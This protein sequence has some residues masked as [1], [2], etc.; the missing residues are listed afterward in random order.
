[1]LFYP[2]FP[3]AAGALFFAQV[4]QR[5]TLM[6]FK[7]ITA[8]SSAANGRKRL[9]NK[10]DKLSIIVIVVLART[11]AR[12]SGFA[13]GGAA[14]IITDA[15]ALHERSAPAAAC[16]FEPFHCRRRHRRHRPSSSSSSRV[17]F[18]P[19]VEESR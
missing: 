1:M 19:P 15:G 11:Y 18:A 2:S 4:Q 6:K 9:S 7:R 14:T 16:S 13:L 5:R 17:R 12:G 8:R 10:T 3:L